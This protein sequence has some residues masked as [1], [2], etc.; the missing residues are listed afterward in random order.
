MFPLLS[1]ECL[2]L[3][4][5]C[6]VV[7][8]CSFPA[9]ILAENLVQVGRFLRSG[10]K[11]SLLFLT[12]QLLGVV[13]E[14]V[15][16]SHPQVATLDSCFRKKCLP[17]LKDGAL[18]GPCFVHLASLAVLPGSLTL[19]LAMFC[20]YSPAPMYCHWAGLPLPVPRLLHV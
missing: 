19:T 5:T 7:V 4:A 15:S 2:T 11:H 1:N 8:C 10:L 17:C 20:V 9:A 12:L 3:D 16:P 6:L 14:L 13:G 18:P